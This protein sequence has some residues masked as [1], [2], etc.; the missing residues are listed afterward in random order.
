MQEKEFIA[1]E[2]AI[3]PVCGIK[4]KHNCGILLDT[5]FKKGFNEKELITHYR[6]CEEHDE[7]RKQGFVFC[8]AIDI[9]KSTVRDNNRASL[10]DVYRTGKFVAMKR[11]VAEQ[12]FPEVQTIMF[13]TD[14]FIEELHT[15]YNKQ[16]KCN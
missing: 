12:V 10:N 9:D 2:A 7:M 3:C 13:V 4:H 16:N 1:L 15:E 8:I 6:M 14:E 5:S 11:E